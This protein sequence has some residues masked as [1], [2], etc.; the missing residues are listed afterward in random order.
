M[1]DPWNDREPIYRQVRDRVVVLILEGLLAE[2]TELPSVRSVAADLRVNPLTVLKGYQLLVEEGLAD[3]RR[4]QCLTVAPGARAALLQGERERFLARE[5]PA[6][7]ARVQR[8][9]LS[10]TDLL[11]T[12]SSPANRGDV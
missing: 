1:A 2:G 10:M 11:A 4:G 9:G 6:L 12:L 7:Q 8:L 3:K 5:W